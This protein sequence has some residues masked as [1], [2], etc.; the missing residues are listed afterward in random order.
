MK[1]ITDLRETLFD[2]IEKLKSGA[3]DLDTAQAINGVSQ[4]IVN[5]AKVE[6]DFHKA[7]GGMG[8]GSGF[9]PLDTVK[10]QQLPQ[11]NPHRHAIENEKGDGG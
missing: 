11:N 2:T 1:N 4:T 8:T 10:V 6:V 9:I 7:Y 3:I 5:S